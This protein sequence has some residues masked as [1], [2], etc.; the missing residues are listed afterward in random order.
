MR[1]QKLHAEALG[2]EQLDRHDLKNTIEEMIDK[3]VPAQEL[4][5]IW[6][7]EEMRFRFRITA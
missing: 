4:Y 2:F 5:I 1:D 7:G 3:T 6:N